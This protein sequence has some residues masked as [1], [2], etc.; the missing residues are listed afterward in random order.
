MHQCCVI[1]TKRNAGFLI[2]FL[3]VVKILVGVSVVGV[4]INIDGSA[5]RMREGGGRLLRHHNQRNM[6]DSCYLP[7]VD[8]PMI[9]FDDTLYKIRAHGVVVFVR[10]CYVTSG[11]AF[12]FVRDESHFCLP[13]SSMH[14]HITMYYFHYRSCSSVLKS[15]REQCTMVYYLQ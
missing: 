10:V 5:H 7:V 14:I 11:C 13:S 2:R 15:S 1:K 6:C 4:L 3:S 8:A 12:V 9:L